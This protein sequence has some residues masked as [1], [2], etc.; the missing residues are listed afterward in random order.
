MANGH[1]GKRPGA[2]KKP[3]PIS[4]IRDKA[5]EEAADDAKY[6]LGLYV[7]VMR[8]DK[9]DMTLRLQCAKEVKDT[10]WGKPSQ[11]VEQSGPDGSELIVRYLNDWRGTTETEE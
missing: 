4:A 9:S 5:I 10:V 2:G 11:R 3:K 1:G 6:A 8:D 7:S